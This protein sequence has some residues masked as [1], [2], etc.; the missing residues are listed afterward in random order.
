MD[1]A[2]IVHRL[3]KLYLEM[4]VN[5]L[6]VSMQ[7]KTNDSKK[8]SLARNTASIAADS[9]N[10]AGK[11]EKLMHNPPATNMPLRIDFTLR[12]PTEIINFQV[13]RKFKKLVWFFESVTPPKKDAINKNKI[14]RFLLLLGMRRSLFYIFTLVGLTSLLGFSLTVFFEEE[15]NKQRET[16]AIQSLAP[17]SFQRD[18]IGRLFRDIA[19]EKFLSEE[20]ILRETERASSGFSAQMKEMKIL[21]KFIPQSGDDSPKAFSD[22]AIEP[23]LSFQKFITTS[24][25]HGRARKI[26]VRKVA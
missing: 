10:D 12:V 9:D 4:T 25:N 2:L 19:K 15:I 5:Y 16:N 21:S 13:S 11:R 6:I 14:L 8:T 7:T 17:H 23:R 26:Y 20:Q 3:T 1:F 22:K 24:I 18:F